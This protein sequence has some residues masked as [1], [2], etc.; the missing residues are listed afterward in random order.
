MSQTS[1]IAIKDFVEALASCFPTRNRP[2]ALYARLIGKTSIENIEPVEK[3][4]Q[5]FRK[6]CIANESQISNK[7][8]ELKEWTIRYSERVYIDMKMVFNFADSDEKSII[9]RHLLTLSALLHPEGNAREIL[10]SSG[11]VGKE[12]DFIGNI[13]NKIENFSTQSDGKDDNNPMAFISNILQSGVFNQLVGG[14]GEGMESGELD[15][16]KLM[17]IAKSMIGHLNPEGKSDGGNPLDAI[18]G[19]AGLASL[20]GNMGNAGNAGNTGNTGNAIQ[21]QNDNE[22][23]DYDREAVFNTTLEESDNK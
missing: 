15:L 6:F 23:E 17:G 14:M 21:H 10:K 3:H 18:G 20:M 16:G 1:F 19:M 4:I 13:M 5:C 2:L 8:C 12:A 9:W 11:A 7:D 22:N